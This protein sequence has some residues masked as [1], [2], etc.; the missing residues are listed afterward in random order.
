MSN[1][2][3]A[4]PSGCAAL[5]SFGGFAMKLIIALALLALPGCN[6]RIGGPS[7]YSQH[8]AWTVVGFLVL[9]GLIL[10]GV[11]GTVASL[12]KPDRGEIVVAAMFLVV[13]GLLLQTLP[14]AA[15][16]VQF[17]PLFPW[18]YAGVTPRIMS[19]A[20]W[21]CMILAIAWALSRVKT[22][23]PAA[24]GAT[25]I[26]LTL[27]ALLSFAG[28]A[29][30]DQPTIASYRERIEHWEAIR[31]ERSE[32]MEKLLADREALVGRIKALGF[33]TK[34]ELTANGVG[35]TLATELEWRR[36]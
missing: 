9:L 22:H 19:A 7:E 17:V 26:A 23:W 4:W 28:P 25:L 29:T 20:C 30:K 11:V 24:A 5:V 14:H 2:G 27:N 3:A 8:G 18:H 32:A 12:S 31:N 10:I 21:L 1:D 13:A 15:N 35:Y 16:G 33:T 36:A 34:R 6:T